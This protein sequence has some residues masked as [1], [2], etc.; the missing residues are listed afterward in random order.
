MLIHPTDRISTDS[1]RDAPNQ[2]TDFDRACRIAESL[3]RVLQ[4][5]SPQETLP[6]V[7]AEAFYEAVLTEATVGGDSC[8]A[9]A[10]AGG[11]TALAVADASGKG[12]AAA[13]RI[14][15]IRYALRAFLREHA[16][17]ARA[18]SCLNDFV[19]DAQRLG[20]RDDCAFATL[21][22]A[23]VWGASGEMSC[24]CAG[25]EPPLVLR[26]GGAVET[27]PVGG[28][29]LGLCPGQSYK[30]ATVCLGRGDTVLVFTDGLT[31]TRRLNPGGSA[32]ARTG[33]FLGLDGLSHLAQQA[34]DPEASLRQISQAI[35]ES[36]RQ[37]GGGSF[38]DDVCLI[39]LARES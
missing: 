30:A 9:F 38:H 1:L 25:G 5:M 27:I 10:L 39:T 3:Q 12:L 28:M 31:E 34:W 21:T 13:E 4:R 16:D 32:L 8:D 22:L 36:V 26:A 33:D 17:P 11:R 18:L 15:E 24:Y 29:A 35:F 19:C 23:I 20:Q 7:C 6:G 37:F 2:Q 14:A